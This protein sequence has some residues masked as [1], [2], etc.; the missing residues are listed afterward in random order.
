ML[1]TVVMASAPA[2]ETFLPLTVEYQEKQF[3]FGQIPR[4]LNRREGMC[5]RWLHGRAASNR[6]CLTL[7]L[8]RHWTLQAW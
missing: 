5:V 3:A 7:R 8:S 2:E 4:S 6:G 1:A